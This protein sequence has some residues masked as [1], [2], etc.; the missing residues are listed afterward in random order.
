MNGSAMVSGTISA[1]CFGAAVFYLT[2]NPAASGLVM[3][4]VLNFILAMRV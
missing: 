1:I 3:A 2:A 4:G